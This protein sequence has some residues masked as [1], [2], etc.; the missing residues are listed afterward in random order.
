MKQR[1][2]TRVPVSSRLASGI[3]GVHAVGVLAFGMSIA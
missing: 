1:I 2:A 3:P